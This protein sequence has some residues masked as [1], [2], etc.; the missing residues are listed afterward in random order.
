[1]CDVNEEKPRRCTY[2]VY[3]SSALWLQK[4]EI[5]FVEKSIL[6][7][8]PNNNKRSV[9]AVTSIFLFYYYSFDRM[10]EE[11]VNKL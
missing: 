9:F 7:R 10:L 6:K 2:I 11:I 5:R 1:M 8:S 3:A 4:T